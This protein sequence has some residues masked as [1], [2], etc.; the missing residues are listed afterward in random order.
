MGGVLSRSS[1]M[2]AE[3]AKQ[4]SRVATSGPDRLVVTFKPGYTFSKS[5][6]E[7]PDQKAK[8]EQVLSELTG[9]RVQVE[10]HAQEGEKPS[11]ASPA[12]RSPPPQRL[13]QIGQH[14]MVRRATELFGAYP[15]R[16]DE[17]K[18]SE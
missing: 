16:L 18:P 8:F 17:S 9:R 10:F 5:V 6:C 4:Y 11:E 14:P 1:G 13:L 3:H 7:G 15:S 12:T 2:A